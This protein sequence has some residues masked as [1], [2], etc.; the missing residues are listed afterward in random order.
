MDSLAAV[1]LIN[2]S[3]TFN[4]FLSTIVDDCRYFLERF[5]L[6]SLKHIFREVN[7]Y[8][9]LLAKVGCAQ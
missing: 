8:V 6:N 1:E 9:D 2:V 3:I 7:D 5:E 4:A